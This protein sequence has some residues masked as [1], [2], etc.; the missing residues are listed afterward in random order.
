MWVK[1][2]S[3]QMYRDY[4]TMQLWPVDADTGETLPFEI[5]DGDLVF[6]QAVNHGAL[7]ACDGP[8]DGKPPVKP[9]RAA[10]QPP[11]AAEPE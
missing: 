3:G 11:A 9:T 2:P 1:P 7:V 5:P 8:A 4:R 10:P 6:A